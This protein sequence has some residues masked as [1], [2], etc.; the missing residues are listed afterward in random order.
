MN[1]FDKEVSEDFFTIEED[2][3]EEMGFVKRFEERDSILYTKK[4]REFDDE[5]A[6]EFV[7]DECWKFKASFYVG[8]FG[9]PPFV[10]DYEL[11]LAEIKVIEKK[12]EEL[13]GDSRT[14]I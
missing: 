7:F 10:D 13:E 14:T 3:V 8:G 12:L 1:N 2:V 4:V 9:G 5:I 6:F 11:S